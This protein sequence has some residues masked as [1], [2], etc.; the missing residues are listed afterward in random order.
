MQRNRSLLVLFVGVIIAFL[1]MVSSPVLAATTKAAATYTPAQLEQVQRYVG[2]LEGFRGRM[3]ALAT[4]IQNRQWTDV[5][6]FIHGPFGE[7]G[8]TTSRL[9]RILLPEVREKAIFA[10]K[11]ILGHLVEIDEAAKNQDYR[12]AIRNYAEAIK[13]FDALFALTPKA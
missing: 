10:S 3:Q 6:S 5:R 13:D 2:T 7:L 1:L 11:G 12:Q 9:T 8:P 4:L